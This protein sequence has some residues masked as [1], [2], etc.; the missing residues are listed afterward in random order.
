MGRIF[1]G[2]LALDEPILDIF[3]LQYILPVIL[4]VIG[5]CSTKQYQKF[6]KNR[7]KLVDWRIYRNK[8]SASTMQDREQIKAVCSRLKFREPREIAVLPVTNNVRLI[9]ECCTG[10]LTTVGILLSISGV[11]LV[12]GVLPPSVIPL[13]IA[14][15]ILAVC[16]FGVTVVFLSL[17]IECCCLERTTNVFVS[18]YE[19]RK[20]KQMAAVD[21]IASKTLLE[22]AADTY[23]IV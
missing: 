1:E 12:P 8:L 18:C 14:L 6:L 5:A 17:V 11:I 23:E 16:F 15:P 2:L 4:P 22:S 9:N 10:I 19:R 3:M 20:Q 21:V 13:K 7:L